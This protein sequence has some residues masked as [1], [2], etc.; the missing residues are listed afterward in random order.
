MRLQT[1]GS[2]PSDEA[3]IHRILEIGQLLPRFWVP[4][5]GK[6]NARCLYPL[7][8]L[9]KEGNYLIA[10][11]IHPGLCAEGVVAA[12]D[13][14]FAVFDLEAAKLAHHVA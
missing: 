2:K 10:V 4:F 3:K 13:G 14:G 9:M 8:V 7:Q 12:G 5:R 1:V 11:E 6:P